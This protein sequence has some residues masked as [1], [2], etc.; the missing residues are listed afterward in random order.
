[1]P[2]SLCEF[3]VS[4]PSWNSVVSFLDLVFDCVY[5]SRAH[6]TPNPSRSVESCDDDGCSTSYYCD[7]T[8]EYDQYSGVA[9]DPRVQVF[10]F[11]F[12]CGC[13]TVCG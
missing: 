1:M 5:A 11:K 2:R 7:V 4:L 8:S 13:V 9:D 6:S 3:L 12:L 10:F